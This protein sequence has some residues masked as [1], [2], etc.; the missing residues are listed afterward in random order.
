V[1]I[2]TKSEAEKERESDRKTEEKKERVGANECEN[3]GK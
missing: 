2:K 1:R 3:S